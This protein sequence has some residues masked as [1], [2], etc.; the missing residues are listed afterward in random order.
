ML[1]MPAVRLRARDWSRLMLLAFQSESEEHPFSSDLRNEVHR[2][3]V[4]DDDVPVKDL[5]TLD[6]WVMY[7]VDWDAPETRLLVH[8]E[9]YTSSALH[10]SVL[11]PLGSALIGIR[12]GDRMPFVGM[13]ETLH[14]VTPI[15]VRQEP[16]A[17]GFLKAAVR[18][19]MNPD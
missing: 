15:E 10:L 9:D 16:S 8:P 17:A 13:G 2:A 5:V 11:S 14:V 6:S 19:R 4:L 3:I 1:E 12:V 18:P 7:V